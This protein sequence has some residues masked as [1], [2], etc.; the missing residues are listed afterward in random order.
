MGFEKKH[1]KLVHTKRA[2]STRYECSLVHRL[3][4]EATRKPFT[5]MSA[6]AKTQQRQRG[7]I[8][9]NSKH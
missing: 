1:E 4:R 7:N 5:E 8:G 9:Q 2:I 3:D 6:R